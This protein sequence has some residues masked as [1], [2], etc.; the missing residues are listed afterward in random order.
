MIDTLFWYTGLAVWGLIVFD[1][2]V[3]FVIDVHDRSAIR[4]IGDPN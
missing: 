3:T 2:I 4:R 1:V